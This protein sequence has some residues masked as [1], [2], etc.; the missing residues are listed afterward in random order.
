MKHNGVKFLAVG[1]GLA[2]AMTA[3]AP[4]EEGGQEGASS[5]APESHLGEPATAD[6]VSEGGTLVF[7]L[8]NDPGPLDPTVSNALVA[9]YVFSSMCE[10]LYSVDAESNYVP[11]LAS[12]LPE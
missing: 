6:Q 12:E 2:L 1:A 3:C 10:S 8:S 9:R 11:T 5:F 4:V 7:A